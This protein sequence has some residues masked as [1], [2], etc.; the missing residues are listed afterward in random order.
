MYRLKN[1]EKRLPPQKDNF[2]ISYWTD[3]TAPMAPHV[4]PKIEP[5]CSGCDAEDACNFLGGRGQGGFLYEWIN[6]ID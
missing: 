4:L 1:D 2:S 6:S 5:G 3:V